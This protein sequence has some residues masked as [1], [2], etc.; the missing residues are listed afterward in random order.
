MLVSSR[1]S[2][3]DLPRLA[4]K[5]WKIDIIPLVEGRAQGV[6]GADEGFIAGNSFGF[7]EL[8][9]GHDIELALAALHELRAFRFGLV[10]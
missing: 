4:L 9:L 6:P 5:S 1:L 10:Q 2:K 7:R 3:I 8:F